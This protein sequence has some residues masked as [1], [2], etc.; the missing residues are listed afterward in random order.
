MR[1]PKVASMSRPPWLERDRTKR[2]STERLQTKSPGAI[3]G[4]L[5]FCG[6]GL[7]RLAGSFVAGLLVALGQGGNC[8]LEIAGQVAFPPECADQRLGLL[9]LEA[10]R[11]GRLHRVIHHRLLGG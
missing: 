5:L 2:N 10:E 4:F 1:W 11:A 8:G 9:H 3:P 6:F 7:P